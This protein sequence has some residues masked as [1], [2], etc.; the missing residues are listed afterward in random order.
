MIHIIQRAFLAAAIIMPQY[1]IRLQLIC[2]YQPRKQFNQTVISLLG[3]LSVLVFKATFYRDGIPV[4]G[5][6]RISDFIQRYDL[7][8][9]PVNAYDKMGAG[10]ANVMIVFQILEII[11][12]LCGTGIRIGRIMHE[13]AV[14]SSSLVPGLEYSL[15]SR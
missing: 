13:N 11:A 7:Q 5:L 10:S 3:K 9:L 8:D 1:V 12:V 15:I 2:A 4:P 6:H 14:N